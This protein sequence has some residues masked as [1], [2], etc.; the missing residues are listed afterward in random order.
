MMTLKGE[1]FAGFKIE[2]QSVFYIVIGVASVIPSSVWI[3]LPRQC[4]K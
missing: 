2:R 3:G 4:R 1:T